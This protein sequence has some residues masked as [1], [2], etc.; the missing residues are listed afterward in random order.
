MSRR[1]RI[2]ARRIKIH[3]SYTVDELA[4][5]LGCH[6]RSVRNWLKNGLASLNDGRRPLLIQGAVAREFLETRSRRT[7]RRCKPDELY[8]LSCRE[9]RLPLEQTIAV[10]RYGRAPAMLFGL[11]S[12]CGSRMFKRVS[13]G[14]ELI[15]QDR[16]GRE[17]EG[18]AQTLKRAA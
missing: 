12:S 13:A 9:P 10:T 3:I 16:T 5:L 2:N 1:E 6:K 7:K 18:G 14:T 11:C 8:C 17:T 4:R 15:I